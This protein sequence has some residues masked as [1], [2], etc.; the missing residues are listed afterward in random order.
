MRDKVA[1][2]LYLLV[3]EGRGADEEGCFNYEYMASQI[4]SLFPD[5][6]KLEVVEE[7]IE[8]EGTCVVARDIGIGPE[9]IYEP[10]P[11]HE[12]EEGK[13]TRPATW[14][15]IDI[16]SLITTSSEIIKN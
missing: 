16:I 1:H 3:E 8:C 14:E 9:E 5:I 2:E 11:C 10:R 6:S 12:C 13:T 4:L 7:C 15:D